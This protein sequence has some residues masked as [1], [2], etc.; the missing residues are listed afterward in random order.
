M[1]AFTKLPAD[2]PDRFADTLL[3]ICAHGSARFAAANQ[4]VRDVAGKI[5]DEGSFLHV[6]TVFHA[7]DRD[8]WT[9]PEINLNQIAR[10]IIVPFMMADGYLAAQMIKTT[11]ELIENAGIN[12]EILGAEAVGTHAKIPEM[13]IEMASRNQKKPENL[14]LVLVAHGSSNAPDS[15][16]AAKAHCRAID[17]SAP[18]RQTHLAFIEEAPFIF[19]TLN[20]IDG[21]AIILGLF[22]A[23]G[24]HAIGDVSDAITKTGRDDLIDAGPIGLHPQMPELIRL[25]AIEAAKL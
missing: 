15:R 9:P 22:A 24:G 7:G 3:I 12:A 1:T 14:N 17:R 21:P 16:V 13:A 4:H 2:T 18:F 8:Q 20:T 10:V 23:P 11:K 25:R 6:Q 19:D 5:R